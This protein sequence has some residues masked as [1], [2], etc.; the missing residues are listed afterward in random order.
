MIRRVLLLSPAVVCGV[1]AYAIWALGGSDV[2]I[3]GGVCALCVAMVLHVYQ[4]ICDAS[5]RCR[6]R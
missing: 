1:W 6:R 2:V 5:R 3:T 4:E